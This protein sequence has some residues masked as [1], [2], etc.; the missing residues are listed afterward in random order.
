MKWTRP[1]SLVAYGLAGAAAVAAGAWGLV[2]AEAADHLDP[3]GRTNPMATP[4]GTDRA[5]DIADVYAWHDSAAGT[6]TLVMTYAGPNDPVAMQRVTCDRNV[7]YTLHIDNDRDQTPDFDV[8]VRFGQDDIGN[9]F[10]RVEGAPGAGGM[11]IEGPVEYTL[12]RGD[13][14]VFAGLRDDPFF[15]DLQ[16]FQTTLMTG[17]LSFV[18][19]RDFFARK[20]S[21]AIVLQLP[22]NAVS[23]TNMPFDVWGT[24]ARIGG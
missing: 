21:S 11:L 15:F 10:V 19:D 7:L 22:L 6:V 13:V 12:R 1:K 16:G 4:P 17:N 2:P 18:N 8:R 24:T 5:A 20:N 9:C 3:P 14:R 23:P